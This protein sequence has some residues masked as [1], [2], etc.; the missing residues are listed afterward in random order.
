MLQRHDHRRYPHFT[1]KSTHL[2]AH[3]RVLERPQG[4]QRRL[5]CCGETP[6]ARDSEALVGAIPPQGEQMLA[7]VQIP[8][9][10]SSIITTTGQPVSIG[11]HSERLDCPLMPSLSL[12]LFGLEPQRELPSGR[13]FAKRQTPVVN[14]LR[15]SEQILPSNLRNCLQS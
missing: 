5:L 3:A 7:T 14:D 6:D 4:A 10:D 1:E 8:E 13:N 12:T 15:R 2:P 11:I 9:H